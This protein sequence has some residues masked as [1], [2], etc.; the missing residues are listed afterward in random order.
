MFQFVEQSFCLC[1]CLTATAVQHGHVALLTSCS[2]ALSVVWLF[3]VHVFMAA[4]DCQWHVGER[5]AEAG[6]GQQH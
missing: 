1:E 3:V 5:A 2:T 4:S 6:L